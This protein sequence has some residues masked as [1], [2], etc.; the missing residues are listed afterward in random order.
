MQKNIIKLLIIFG[1]CTQCSSQ[2]SDTLFL[3]NVKNEIGL[4][5]PIELNLPKVQDN[6]KLLLAKSL[7]NPDVEFI[8]QKTPS[9]FSPNYSSD[10]SCFSTILTNSVSDGEYRITSYDEKPIFKIEENKNGQL[11]VFE[12]GNPALTYNFGMQLKEGV[13]KRYQRSSYI[14]PIYDLKGNILTD[15]FPDDHYHH[16]GLSWMWP[17]IF[18]DSVRYDLWHIYGQQG[19]LEGIHQVF[20][21]WLMKEV[22]PI[23][24][25]FGAKNIWQLD[26][27]QKVMDEW[28][29]VKVYKA[30]ENSR[31]IDIKLVFKASVEIG[32]EGQTK[33]GYGGLN[34]RFSPRIETKITS[35]FGKE[36]DSDLKSLPWADQSAIFGDN[37]YFS[38]VSIFQRKSNNN[39]PAGWCLRHYG[40]LGVEWPGVERYNMNPG[41]TFTLSFRILV[42]Q[43]NAVEGSVE[44]AYK[45]FSDPPVVE[46]K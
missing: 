1:I 7:D 31:A 36:E 40:F 24:A 10:Y 42:H 14:H 6:E 35:Q 23:C 5:I 15:D 11:T 8:L 43:G 12:E 33:K 37:N 34:F 30:N 39:F 4:E 26:S 45:I 38:G 19:D 9:F 21:K 27:G 28:V 44:S 29:Y 46:Y 22:G 18:I 3:L 25:T 32:L 13:P 20:E 2:T 16:R 41:E 17:K